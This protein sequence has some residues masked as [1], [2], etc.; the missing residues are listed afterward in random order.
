MKN[1]TNFNIGDNV[2]WFDIWDN[3]C[4]GTILEIH[5]T[6]KNIR[7]FH[8]KEDIGARDTLETDC[9]PTKQAC[10]DAFHEKS[11]ATVK[12][13]KTEIHSVDELVAFC[14]THCVASAEE[15]TN[16]DARKAVLE[17]AKELGLSLPDNL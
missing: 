13:Y 6:D 14:L 11:N 3:L 16:Y 12:A 4:H 15:Y 17:R 10:L 1:N 2:W 5:T 9:Y 7:Y 8:V